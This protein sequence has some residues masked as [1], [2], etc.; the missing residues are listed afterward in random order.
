VVLTGGGAVTAGLVFIVNHSINDLREREARAALQTLNT[1][2]HATRGLL[3]EHSRA[4]ERLRISRDL[5][6]TLGHHLTGL[7]IQLDVAARRSEGPAAEHIREAHAITRLL[8]SDVR[9]VVG[10]LRS[11][12][13]VNLAEQIRQLT[14][15]ID[16]LKIHLEMPDTLD[17]NDNELADTLVRCVQEII[18]NARRHAAARNLWI[19]IAATATGLEL[20]AHDDGC[21]AK[22]VKWGLGLTGMRERF[23]QHGGHVQIISDS[24]SGFTVHAVLPQPGAAP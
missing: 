18:T 1:E 19:A 3:A 16:E 5:H 14:N 4:A 11:T 21:G 22:Q 2:L 24:Q 23:A 8:L 17:S 9:D 6:D 13:N 10:Q 15:G 7:S 20:R 12:G